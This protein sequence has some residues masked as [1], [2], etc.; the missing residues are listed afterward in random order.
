[1]LA[2]GENYTIY[3]V[4][5]TGQDWFDEFRRNATSLADLFSPEDLEKSFPGEL[6]FL[7]MSSDTFATKGSEN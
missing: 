1:M 4:L 3:G 5:F 2:W 6:L 7:Q